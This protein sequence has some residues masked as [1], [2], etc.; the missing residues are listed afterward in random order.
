M[1][2][3]MFINFYDLQ[4][5]KHQFQILFLFLKSEFS[6]IYGNNHFGWEINF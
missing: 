3:Q 4:S 2:K 1:K 6:Y 5:P